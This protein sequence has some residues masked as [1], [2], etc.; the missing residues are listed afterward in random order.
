M[1]DT[2]PPPTPTDSNRARILGAA[3]GTQDAI[4]MA[5]TADPALAAFL[6]GKSLA[7]SL[8]IW[9]N[10]LAPIIGA[11]AVYFK[12]GLD[13]QTVAALT[14][15]IVSGGNMFLRTF[16]PQSPITGILIAAPVPNDA[17][18]KAAK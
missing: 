8:T 15:A 14:V 7:G 4:R 17:T 6:A 9:F 18:A 3:T 10:V 5:T 12:L 1:S 16:R 2:S 11:A 13:A